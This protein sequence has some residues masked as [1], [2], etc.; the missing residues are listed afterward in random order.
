[1]LN[2]ID[3]D[4]LAPAIDSVLSATTTR[5]DDADLDVSDGDEDEDEGGGGERSGQAGGGLRLHVSLQVCE[6]GDRIRLYVNL[7]LEMK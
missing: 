3:E 6:E 2:D 5:E 4:H 1:M 7:P